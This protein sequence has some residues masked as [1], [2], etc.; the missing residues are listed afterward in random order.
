MNFLQGSSSGPAICG[1]STRTS[2]MKRSKQTPRTTPKSVRSRRMSASTSSTS[3][4]Q[5]RSTRGVTSLLAPLSQQSSILSFYLIVWRGNWSFTIS[6]SSQ[7][8]VMSNYNHAKDLEGQ[9]LTLI[10][11]IVPEVER[12]TAAKSIFRRLFHEWVEGL[13]VGMSGTGVSEKSVADSVSKCPECN[14]KNTE[15]RQHHSNCS[16]K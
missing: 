11:A 4:G 3:M 5:T 16:R 6:V 7:V 1:S 8:K 15:P 10:E 2:P 14:F 13:D 9:V 12:A